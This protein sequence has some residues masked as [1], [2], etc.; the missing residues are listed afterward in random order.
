MAP[1]VAYQPAKD[2]TKSTAHSST[3][4][5]KESKPPK[6]EKRQFVVVGCV[7]DRSFQQ[8]KMVV[9]TLADRHP[10]STSCHVLAYMPM[11][12]YE[13][14]QKLKKDYETLI[15]ALYPTVL[16]LQ[17]PT[18][19]SLSALQSFPS[20]QPLQT[21]AKS[22]PNSTQKPTLMTALDLVT[23]AKDVYG[24]EDTRPGPLYIGLAMAAVVEEVQKRREGGSDFIYMDITSGTSNFGRLVFE[25]YASTCPQTV[26]H[27]LRFITTTPQP[28]T[29]SQLSYKNTQFTRV[30]PGGWI[31]GGE[32][33][34]QDGKVVVEQR[35]ADENYIHPHAHRGTLSLA[36]AGPHS[37][38]SQ[39]I[40]A[41][42]AKPYF[43]KKYVCFGRLVDGE[44]T[45]R[46]M[47]GV[48]CVMERPVIAVEV[49]GC[50]VWKADE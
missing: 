7:G 27:F 37:A 3:G 14:R 36:N 4:H 19:S 44:G 2:E 18:A 10:T 33:I 13:F 5:N 32:I 31:Q 39:F 38:F 46:K 16:I 40:I 25:L 12:Y 50:G 47:E 28:T 22:T 9:E 34:G 17:I 48:S 41:L 45:L 20:L 8:C 1:L 42:T 23:L 43:D 24:F 49:A 30:L 26:S 6:D 15:D 35:L 21:F 11:E 29:N